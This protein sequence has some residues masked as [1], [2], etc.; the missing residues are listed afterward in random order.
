MELFPKY[1]HSEETKSTDMD[2][3]PWYLRTNLRSLLCRQIHPHQPM[4]SLPNWGKSAVLPW[5]QIQKIEFINETCLKNGAVS[6]FF[7]PFLG[8]N[9]IGKVPRVGFWIVHVWEKKQR[10]GSTCRG[11][12]L[13]VG[14]P[15][16]FVKCRVITCPDV[17]F[18]NLMIWRLLSKERMER[19]HLE[20]MYYAYW[21]LE[22]WSRFCA[23]APLI[24]MWLSGEAGGE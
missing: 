19:N 22:A 5:S 3:F 14:A 9:Y 24:L 6:A 21:Y 1:K 23:S 7:G 8:G 18:L 11:Q 12:P 10:L 17:T 13:E 20:F 2:L 15:K 16:W 4:L